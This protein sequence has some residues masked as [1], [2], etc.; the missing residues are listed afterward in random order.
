MPYR[1]HVVKDRFK[2]KVT[3]ITGAGSGIGRVMAGRFAREGSAVVI[4][5]I[6]YE[7]ARETADMLKEMGAQALALKADVSNSQDIRQFVKETIDAFGKINILINNAGITTRDP[8]LEISEESWN[9]EISIDL[10]GTAFCIK[11]VAPEIIKAGGGKIINISSVAALIGAVAPAY[12]AAKGGII[13]LT[14]VLAGELAPHK[15]NVNVIC[16]G[17]VATPINEKMRKMGME[18]L[19]QARIPWGRWGTPEDVVSAV[20]FLASDEA[21]FITGAV[22][23]VDGAM[24]SY[25]SLGQE[26]FTADKK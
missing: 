10:S 25:I 5:D 15:V 12:S 14:K 9:K 19:I 7:A 4:P 8:L 18:K 3:V 11:Y 21:D 13:S 2:D 20:V 26:Y 23:Q 16:P 24:G 22:L 6:N 17:F 1:E